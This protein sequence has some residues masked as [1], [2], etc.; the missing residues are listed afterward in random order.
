MSYAT[1]QHIEAAV[2]RRHTKCNPLMIRASGSMNRYRNRSFSLAHGHLNKEGLLCTRC[3]LTRRR[4]HRHSIIRSCTASLFLSRFLFSLTCRLYIRTRARTVDSL[5][6]KRAHLYL[7]VT[8]S[9]ESRLLHLYRQFTESLIY[10]IQRKNQP[11]D[12]SEFRNRVQLVGRRQTSA[13]L[14]L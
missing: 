3:Y 1:E 9:S 11:G 2:I 4:N 8:S 14:S 13:M 12:E 10:T 7:L 5:V 6:N